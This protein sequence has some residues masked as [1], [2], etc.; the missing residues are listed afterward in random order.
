MDESLSEINLASDFRGRSDGRIT[1]RCQRYRRL[2]RRGVRAS[3]FHRHFGQHYRWL[4]FP[5]VSLIRLSGFARP[6]LS[7]P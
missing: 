6:P 3:G 7:A 2:K 5:A 1:E 4:R